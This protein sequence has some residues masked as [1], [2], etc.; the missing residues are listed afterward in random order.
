MPRN[1][2][3]IDRDGYVN[4]ERMINQG[5]NNLIEYGV[6]CGN[7]D[8][9][10]QYVFEDDGGRL[11]DFWNMCTKPDILLDEI[12]RSCVKRRFPDIEQLRGTLRC[13]RYEPPVHNNMSI[14]YFMDFKNIETDTLIPKLRMRYSYYVQSPYTDEQRTYFILSIDNYKYLPGED[15]EGPCQTMSFFS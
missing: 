4:V 8:K 9:D 6:P 14:W 12:I 10:W 2:E 1:T 11:F 13:N 15:F 5:L 3:I 7:E